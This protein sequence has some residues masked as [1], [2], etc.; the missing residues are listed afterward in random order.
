[1][2]KPLILI[3]VLLA[4]FSG[5]RSKKQLV[6]PF[7]YHCHPKSDF[8]EDLGIVCLGDET[9]VSA[10]GFTQIWSDA[11]VASNC[12]KPAFVGGEFESVVFYADCRI[13]PGYRGSLFS[14]CAVIQYGDL[15]CPA[16]WRVPTKEDFIKLDLILDGTGENQQQNTALIHNYI[17]M[18]EGR[19]GGFTR[20]YGTRQ[21]QGWILGYWSQSEV[22]NTNAHLL[23]INN[24]IRTVS[25][26]YSRI[27]D[28]GFLVRCVRD[29]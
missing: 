10:H 18:W 4:V 26:Q 5:C 21:N 2:K 9:T 7:P 14:W 24:N 13:N 6:E 16:P 12:N 23:Y 3:V 25:P 19:F 22:S 1:M 28:Q 29:L 20:E 11:V 27:K 15:L 8:V 17:N